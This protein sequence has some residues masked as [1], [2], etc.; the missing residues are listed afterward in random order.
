[1]QVCQSVTCYSDKDNW[2][3]SRWCFEGFRASQLKTNM[4]IIV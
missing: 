2:L 1:M 4:K 3:W